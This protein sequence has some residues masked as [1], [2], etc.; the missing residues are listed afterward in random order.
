MYFVQILVCCPSNEGVDM[1]NLG[2]FGDIIL[3]MLGFVFLV[4]GLVLLSA[5]IQKIYSPTKE[6]E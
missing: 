3:L 5:L 1:G 6:E 2:S 4:F